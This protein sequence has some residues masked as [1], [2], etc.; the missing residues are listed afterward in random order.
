MV[1]K[2]QSVFLC[3]KDYNSTK[4]TITLRSGIKRGS[5]QVQSG[6]KRGFKEGSKMVGTDLELGLTGLELGWVW[7]QA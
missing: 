3:L 7:G 5:N 2:C 1:T 4:L 6:F